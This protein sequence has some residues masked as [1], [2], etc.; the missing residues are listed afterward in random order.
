MLI[1]LEEI[2]IIGCLPRV[3]QHSRKQRRRVDYFANAGLQYPEAVATVL[4]IQTMLDFI[5]DLKM[6]FLEANLQRLDS[7]P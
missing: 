3:E 5:A 2:V 7:V 6:L 4:K 1:D